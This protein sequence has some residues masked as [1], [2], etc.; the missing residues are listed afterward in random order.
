[1][2][3]TNRYLT[4]D[5]QRVRIVFSDLITGC[6][7]QQAVWWHTLKIVRT[8]TEILAA[9]SEQQRTGNY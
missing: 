9:R 6:L 3:R 8:C 2:N 7:G 4:D 1:M 5:E